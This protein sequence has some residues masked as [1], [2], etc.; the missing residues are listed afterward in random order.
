MSESTRRLI[1]AFEFLEMFFGILSRRQIAIVLSRLR[2][3]LQVRR[4]K[5]E[6]FTYVSQP[7]L[8][9]TW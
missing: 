3:K 1:D 8:I 7:Q 4:R 6:L 2:H 9:P 5:G